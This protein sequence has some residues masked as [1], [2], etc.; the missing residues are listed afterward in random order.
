[1]RCLDLPLRSVSLTWTVSPLSINLN[2]GAV[3]G[4]TIDSNLLFGLVRETND[5]CEPTPLPSSSAAL[6]LLTG[7]RG[8]TQRTDQQLGSPTVRDDG[9][10]GPV[11][12]DRYHSDG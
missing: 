8:W 11:V 1:M 5:Q 3:G 2:D 6:A 9:G 7:A 12:S 10:D 4:N